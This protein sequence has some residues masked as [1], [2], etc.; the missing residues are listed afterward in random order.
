MVP[1]FPPLP[2]K[3]IFLFSKVLDMFERGFSI[4]SIVER[5]PHPRPTVKSKSPIFLEETIYSLEKTPFPIKSLKPKLNS[6]KRSVSSINLIF[7]LK[8][9]SFLV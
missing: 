9:L 5:D 7:K 1:K 2:I 3:E 4:P 8:L 6:G